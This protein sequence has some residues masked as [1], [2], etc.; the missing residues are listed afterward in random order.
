MKK[1]LLLIVVV[2]TAIET[3][4]S[5]TDHEGHFTNSWVVEIRGGEELAHSIAK[6][7]GF[8][9]KGQVDGI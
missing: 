2:L 9:N 8:T 1:R 6:Q 7:H 4:V 5:E 3:I